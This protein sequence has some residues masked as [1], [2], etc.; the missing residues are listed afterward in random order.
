MTSRL[1]LPVDA[2]LRGQ[3][4]EVRTSA[5]TVVRKRL[6]ADFDRRVASDFSLPGDGERFVVTGS[7]GRRLAWGTVVPHCTKAL[8]WLGGKKAGPGAELG[9]LGHRAEQREVAFDN[10]TR[11]IGGLDRSW[12]GRTVVVG[13]G[14]RRRSNCR[15]TRGQQNQDL[16]H[17]SIIFFL[18][19]NSHANGCELGSQ[20]VATGVA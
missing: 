10:R 11:L 13:C 7:G 9:V 1:S 17:P 5:R 4:R 6:F 12:L 16:S 20:S 18:A 14:R 2:A 8:A 19:S 15:P 3:V